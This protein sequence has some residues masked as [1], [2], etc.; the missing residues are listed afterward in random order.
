[1]GEGGS[2]EA[3]LCRPVGCRRSEVWWRG[4]RGGETWLRVRMVR[5][6]GG[7][8]RPGVR[9]SVVLSSGR[10]QESGLGPLGGGRVL[11]RRCRFG[12]GLADGAGQR[13]PAVSTFA[14]S[15]WVGVRRD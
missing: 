14:V 11:W 8:G 3:L 4:G 7:R 5:S 2:D 15:E 12:L 1:M 6:V 10:V 9:L 13:R